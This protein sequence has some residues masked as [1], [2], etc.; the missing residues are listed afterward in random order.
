MLVCVF[1]SKTSLG[2][3]IRAVDGM[4]VGGAI[5]STF[6]KIDVY[7]LE[8]LVSFVSEAAERAQCSCADLKSCWFLAGVLDIVPFPPFIS[9]F[10]FPGRALQLL[11]SD[12]F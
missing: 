12:S 5:L 6:K 1:F 4:H 8:V 10:W 3:G 7:V 2:S 9:L 11:L